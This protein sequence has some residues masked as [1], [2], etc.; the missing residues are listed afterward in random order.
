[1]YE[2]YI[3]SDVTNEYA[4]YVPLKTFFCLIPPTI[5]KIVEVFSVHKTKKA[6]TMGL[7]VH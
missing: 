1:M 4:R 6:K 7:M 5:A 3:R 2:M